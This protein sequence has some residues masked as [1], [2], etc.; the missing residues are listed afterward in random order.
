MARGELRQIGLAEPAD[1]MD[2][3]V[4]RQPKAYPVYDVSY[5]HH[6]A[7]IRSALEERFPSLHVCG[8][9][10]MHKYNNQDH[11]MMTAILVVRNILAGSRV[12]DVWQV[13]QDAEYIEEGDQTPIVGLRATPQRL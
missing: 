3:H 8:R 6:C 4:V 7:V 5:E 11:S 12:F 1:V 2:G 13:N 10:G 9:N